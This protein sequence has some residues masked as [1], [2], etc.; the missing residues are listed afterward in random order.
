M[1]YPI[2]YLDETDSTNSYL[3]DL[4]S[5]TTVE[6]GTIVCS[7]VQTS[8]RGQRGNSW[9][10]EKGKNLL[11]STVLYPLFIKT[12][13]QFILSQIVS[14]AV[15]ECLDEYTENI[16]IK[17]PNDIYW[18]E[19]KICGILIENTILEDN[20]NQSV[21]GIGIN[22]NQTA[23][24]SDAPNPVSLKQ[25]TEADHDPYYL[26]NKIHANIFNYYRNIREGNAKEILKKYKASLFRADGFYRYND[27]ATDFEARI[28][29]VKPSGM[30]VLE[31]KDGK[32]REFAF[33]EVKYIL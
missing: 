9:E 11:F 8:G 20:I 23:F 5:N 16:S 13:E 17:W 30:L 14:L 7:Q 28:K 2:L 26:L 22:I 15:K 4:I 10:S 19:K 1:P 33:K 3:K 24:K 25:V 27:G 29:D 18:Q 6:E 12:Y 32:E 31:T 21:I